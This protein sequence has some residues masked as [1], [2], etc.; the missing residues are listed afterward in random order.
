[1]RLYSRRGCHLCQQAEELLYFH[2]PAAVAVDVDSEA[3]LVGRYGER[4][5][6]LEIDGRVVLE[7]RFDEAE[8]IRALAR[9]AGDAPAA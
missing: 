6:V 1:M 9:A 8:L 3:A 2:A 5:P 4:V 7:G